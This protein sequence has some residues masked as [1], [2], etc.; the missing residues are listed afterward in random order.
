MLAVAKMKATFVSMDTLIMML[1]IFGFVSALL[2]IA[3]GWTQW[4]MTRKRDREAELNSSS[5][6]KTGDRR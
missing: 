4:D 6:Q 5:S 1:M 3:A 2:L